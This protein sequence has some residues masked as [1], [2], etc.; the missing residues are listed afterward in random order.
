MNKILAA[1]TVLL[2]LYGC[3]AK[4]TPPIKIETIYTINDVLIEKYN[5]NYR[6]QFFYSKSPIPLVKSGKYELLVHF[7]IKTAIS[8]KVLQSLNTLPLPCKYT[9]SKYSNT[10]YLRF[11]CP[12]NIIVYPE[13]DHETMDIILKIAG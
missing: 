7:D 4:E 9:G 3:A 2:I 10:F 11:A 12:E 8:Q 13:A 5:N 1:I 6:L